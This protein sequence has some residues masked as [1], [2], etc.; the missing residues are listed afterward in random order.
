[1]KRKGEGNG[2]EQ[3]HNAGGQLYVW[4]PQIQADSEII[5]YTSSEP[6]W[7]PQPFVEWPKER[8]MRRE[9]S[10]LVDLLVDVAAAHII[11]VRELDT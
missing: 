11:E 2:V 3:Q 7:S 9:W 4:V 8:V 1:M 5:A 10:D 6:R